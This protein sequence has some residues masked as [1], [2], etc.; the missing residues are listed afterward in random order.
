MSTMRLRPLMGLLVT[1]CV[2]SPPPPP[3]PA[4][5]DAT[6]GDATLAVDATSTSDP[7]STGT[8]AAESTSELSSTTEAVC[9]P[10]CQAGQECFGGTCFDMPGEST[11]GEP[12][13]ECGLAVQLQYPNP[14]C[15]PCAEASCCSELQACFGDETTKA[16]DCLE[17]NNCIATNCATAMSLEEL[18]ACV[19][20]MCP[21]Y[22]RWFETWIA[23]QAC[24]GMSCQTECT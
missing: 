9:D 23:F 24:L 7:G 17:L 15:A 16:T 8:T 6:T 5:T 21:S 4:A 13:A 22:A 12:P 11:T 14:Q 1:A 10:P 18:Q 20:A 19:D 3:G 2:G